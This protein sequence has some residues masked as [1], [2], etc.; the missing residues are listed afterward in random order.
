MWYC[1]GTITTC[2]TTCYPIANTK[3]AESDDEVRHQHQ[4]TLVVFLRLCPAP[5]SDMRCYCCH[6]THLLSLALFK[7]RHEGFQAVKHA[8][9]HEMS[10][11]GTACANQQH[12]S[13][14]AAHLRDCGLDRT[15]LHSTRSDCKS[16]WNASSKTDPKIQECASATSCE[17]TAGVR[18][19]ARDANQHY[20]KD[21]LANVSGSAGVQ[22][23]LSYRHSPLGHLH[24]S[25]C[26]PVTC[27][28]MPY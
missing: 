9:Q 18:Q 20:L 3:T 2:A 22:V 6:S 17:C 24:I 10:C 1:Y 11:N 14:Q 12:C 28:L 13:P 25:A 7:H 4:T 5:P 16:E 26:Q 23:H 21:I 19:H 15:S 27:I 8:L